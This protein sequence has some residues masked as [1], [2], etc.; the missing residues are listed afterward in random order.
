M[1]YVFRPVDGNEGIGRLFPQQRICLCD[2]R[3][4]G[5]NVDDEHDGQEKF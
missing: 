2:E 1:G 5:K 4:P 3:N